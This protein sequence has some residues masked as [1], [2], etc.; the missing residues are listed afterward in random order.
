MKGSHLWEPWAVAVAAQR[1][2]VP[3]LYQVN[4]DGRS[5]LSRAMPR[6]GREG[7]CI[8]AASRRGGR[9]PPAA[10]GGSSDEGEDAWSDPY[11]QYNVSTPWSLEAWE[12]EDG[13]CAR[14]REPDPDYD[15]DA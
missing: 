11:E 9:V 3:D 2:R 10:R 13:V 6:Q 5:A 15:P 7:D 12:M 1:Q 4:S 14:T 8:R